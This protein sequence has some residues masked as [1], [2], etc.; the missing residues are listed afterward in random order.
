M[1]T[2]ALT[3]CD[4]A[5][6]HIPGAWAG[7]GF[8]TGR[9]RGRQSWEHVAGN[10]LPMMDLEG[11]LL[12]AWAPN[13]QIQVGPPAEKP[14]LLHPQNGGASGLEKLCTLPWAP[15]V[16][17][18]PTPAS[19]FRAAPLTDDSTLCR[20]AFQKL[21]CPG[22]KG[23]GGGEGRPKPWVLLAHSP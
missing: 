23:L 17:Y 7:F 22:D 5:W 8:K 13:L 4:L 6:C 21:V 18:F 9:S 10:V 15:C 20:V 11:L 19:V 1:L 2:L 3:P 14:D 16:P 12:S